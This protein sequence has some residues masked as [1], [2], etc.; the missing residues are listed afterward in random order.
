MEAHE[1]STTPN[2]LSAQPL[3]TQPGVAGIGPR[4]EE[5]RPLEDV[6]RL[7]HLRELR[8]PGSSPALSS[9]QA[10]YPSALRFR[11]HGALSADDPLERRA[12]M[13]DLRSGTC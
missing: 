10:A 11:G 12:F 1:I 5:P 3:A 8:L 2:Q 4:Q 6:A 7:A 9:H 13:M